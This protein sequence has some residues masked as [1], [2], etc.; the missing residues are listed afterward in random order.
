MSVSPASTDS[1]L[2]CTRPHIAA[3]A[4]CLLSGL[5]FGCESPG[6]DDQDAMDDTLG[7]IDAVI[8]TGGMDIVLHKDVDPDAPAPIDLLGEGATV[9]IAQ[10]ASAI[11]EWECKRVIACG[12]T[13]PKQTKPDQASCVAQLTPA[14]AQAWSNGGLVARADLIPLCV[15]ALEADSATCAVAKLTNVTTCLATLRWP[16]KKG[17]TCGGNG[18]FLCADGGLCEGGKCTGNHLGMIAVG[19]ACSNPFVCGTA[20]CIKNAAGKGTCQV[21]VAAG[22]PCTNVGDCEMP[23]L[24]KAGI[25][26]APA[27]ATEKCSS[28]VD[29][30]PGLDCVNGACAV[31]AFCAPG[32][33]CGNSGQCLGE[34]HNACAAQKAVNEACK[35]DS[36]CV[37]SAYCNATAHVCAARPS[38]GEACG[39]GV[40]CAAGLGCETGKTTCEAL[41]KAGAKCLLGP[42]GPFLC[43]PGA[44]CAANTFICGTPPGENEPCAADNTCSDADIDGDGKKGDLA[45]NFTFKGSICSKK[46]ALGA[47]CQNEACQDGLFCDYSTGKCAK[48]YAA[49]SACKNGNECGISAACNPNASSKLVCGPLPGATQACLTSCASGLYCD[50]GTASATCQPPVCADLYV[51]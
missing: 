15:A 38:L 4:I 3:A 10:L 41:P 9:P 29:C 18:P 37:A 50:I 46:L 17:D 34:I 20:E 11:A 23:A 6:R 8:D 25:C 22:N 27:K 35:D 45:C 14:I 7:V 47:Q 12:C 39:N 30:G 2:R 48:P 13:A 26:A 1:I 33:T 32:N 43:A 31:P 51:L 5:S 21:P 28:V 24:C 16:G 36:E 42:A 44:S 40:S 19:Q 49:G